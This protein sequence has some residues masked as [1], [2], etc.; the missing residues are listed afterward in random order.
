MWSPVILGLAEVAA[1][2]LLVALAVVVAAAW[3]AGQ[4][5]ERWLGQPSVL[6]EIL[7]GIALGPS[8]LG[9]VWPAATSLLFPPDV[10]GGLRVIAEVGLVLFMFLV[11]VEVDL[12]LMRGVGRQAPIISLSSIV[13]PL[14]LGALVSPILAASLMP[15]ADQPGFALFIGVAMAITAFPVLA[16]LLQQLGIERTVPGV[17]AIS[18]AAIGDVTAWC[19]LAAIVAFV[20]SSGTGGVLVSVAGGVVFAVVVMGL[21]RPILQRVRRVPLAVAVALGLGGAWVTGAIGIHAIFGAFLVGLAMPRSDGRAG[22]LERRLEAVTTTVLL[23][24]FF[25]VAGLAVDVG[26]LGSWSS[27]AATV[28]AVAV[29]V[30]GKVG[31]TTLTA[32]VLHFG[33][34]DSFGLGL[35]MNTRGLTEIVILA[36]GLQ[37]GVIDDAV[38]TAMVV[39]ALATTLIAA[40]L[41]QA[42]GIAARWRRRSPVG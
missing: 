15:D 36:V 34:D 31:G 37:L 4:A 21:L 41:L 16:R 7:A 2:R 8:V 12:T 33:W 32:R 29:A 14:L 1:D 13:V 27:I 26:S 9:A 42:S 18:S 40:P 25:V 19:L 20:E 23:P 28:V 39:M 3:A 17:L 24:V 5:L 22:E 11:G 38:Y 6:G 10:V 30:V 35:L